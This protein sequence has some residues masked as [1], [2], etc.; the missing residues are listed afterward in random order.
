MRILVHG[1]GLA[2]TLFAYLAAGGKARH[3][4]TLAQGAGAMPDELGIVF[5]D[6]QFTRLARYA[7]DVVGALASQWRRWDRVEIRRGA[8]C[9]RIAAGD[10]HAI[11]ERALVDALRQPAQESGCRF[12]PSDVALASAQEFDLVVAADGRGSAIRNP[13]A[14]NFE[15]SVT[16]GRNRLLLAE[17]DLALDHPVFSLRSGGS[18]FCQASF[19]PI[20]RDR[21]LI[22]VEA[23]P[24]DATEQPGDR[25]AA[26]LAD[27]FAEDLAGHVL[28]AV[29]GWQP[30]AFFATHRRV[31]GR[32]VLLGRSAA[33]THPM[34]GLDGRAEI[35]DAITLF[36]CL[37]DAA[38]IDLAL[39]AYEET[40]LKSSDSAQRASDVTRRWGEN[41]L[42]YR[43]QDDLQFAFNLLTR[44]YRTDW[45]TIGKRDPDF[46]KNVVSGFAARHGADPTT[47]PMF[48][49]FRL[50]GLELPNRIVFSPMAMRQGT[51]DATPTDFHLVH[52][53]SRAM[54]G[55]GLVFGEMTSVS[56]E[57]R[58]SLNCVGIYRPEHMVE[59]RRIVD[60]V[61]AQSTAKIGLQLGHAGRKGGTRRAPD[62]RNVPL[63][64]GGW[65]LL[66]ASAIPWNARAALPKEVDRKDMDKIVED[67]TRGAKHGVSC[68]FDLIE[69]HMAHGYLLSS[70]I[71][72]VSNR[73]RDAYGGILVNRMRFPLEVLRAVRAVW[74]AQKPI[75]VRISA[76][77][78]LPDGLDLDEAVVVARMLKEAGCD[79]VTVSSGHTTS[80]VG[81][82][83]DHGRLYQTPFSDRIRNEVGIPTMAVG[84][85]FSWGDVNSVL[86]AGRADLCALGRGILFDPYFT[87]HA[88]YAQGYAM[89]W[90]ASYRTAALFKSHG[91]V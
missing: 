44:H 82:G 32:I 53:G 7:P 1:N 38:D 72:P 52:L 39:A 46:I 12:L 11:A 27:V 3:D 36:E 24:G 34:L 10:R 50:R 28:R 47:P 2:A 6:G 91:S 54:G 83:P 8:S 40:R 73:R 22:L 14:T 78:W 17:A 29:T 48:C 16:S 61:H 13:G 80:G 89:K 67:Y 63:E 79:M 30:V 77:D 69:I 23:A 86:A 26:T 68:G 58:I 41:L 74:P 60:F 75:T 55:S 71:S 42:L 15:L 45:E 20:F 64:E 18:T 25:A 4:V 90:P 33:A 21:S 88:A 37:R 19:L 5:D 57:G 51:P 62:G 59:W 31:T 49:P 9:T 81:A 43:A 85:I 70:F 84:T 65:E 66:S 56:P 76:Y 35:E 87:R